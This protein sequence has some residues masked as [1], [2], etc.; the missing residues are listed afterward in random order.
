MKSLLVT[1]LVLSQL[2]L[3]DTRFPSD[4]QLFSETREGCDHFRGEPWSQGDKPDWKERRD[5][6][7]KNIEELCKG[8]DKQLA[9]LRA[10]YRENP[11]V[12]ERLRRY[13]DHVELP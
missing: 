5:F 3:A 7:F 13:D 12:I 1:L 10:K 2:V 4:V 8:T 11:A 9:E 6:I